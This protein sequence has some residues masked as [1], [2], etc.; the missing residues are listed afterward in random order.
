MQEV[1]P[2]Y[3]FLPAPAARIEDR[4][5]PMGP[6]EE[7]DQALVDATHLLP[8]GRHEIRHDNGDVTWINKSESLGQDIAVV[9]TVTSDGAHGHASTLISKVPVHKGPVNEGISADIGHSTVWDQASG[10]KAYV[11]G[12]RIGGDVTRMKV[13][14]HRTEAQAIKLEI[15]SQIDTARKQLGHDAVEAAQR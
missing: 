4:T 15:A 13:G 10:S 5:Q 2:A 9:D 8:K 14:T 11:A 1:H 6:L 12:N 7:G 3:D